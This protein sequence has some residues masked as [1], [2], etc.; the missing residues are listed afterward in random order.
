MHR[1]LGDSG[2]REG[3][4]SRRRLGIAQA[5][6]ALRSACTRVRPY[7]QWQ[8]IISESI[9]VVEGIARWAIRATARVNTLG[10][11]SA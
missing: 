9:I 7:T 5:S 8:G 11:A 4:Y 6:L 3:K 1:P 2:D 10:G